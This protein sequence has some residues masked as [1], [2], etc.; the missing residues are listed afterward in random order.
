M[1]AFDYTCD[2]RAPDVTDPVI[3]GMEA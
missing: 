2:C 3:L 1:T